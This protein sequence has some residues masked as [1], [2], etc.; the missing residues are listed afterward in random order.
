MSTM[1]KNKKDDA[2]S[3]VVGVMLMLVV[4]I[5][6]AAVVAAFASGVATDTNAASNVVIKLDEYDMATVNYTGN[7]PGPYQYSST[8]V[9]GSKENYGVYQMIFQH[10]GGDKLQV[11][12][13]HLVVT[14]K[15]STY[16]TS[17]SEVTNQKDWRVG[18]KLILC[19]DESKL[20]SMTGGLLFGLGQQ[21][22][23]AYEE[24]DPSTFDWAITDGSGYVISKGVAH[25]I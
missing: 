2:V 6:I 10:N 12:D 7:F 17:F 19:L 20:S 4:T 16:T 9:S 13:L 5:I 24:T 11:E 1:K 14:Y 18:Q 21:N 8:A 3:P 15:Q 25:I 22:M 23:M